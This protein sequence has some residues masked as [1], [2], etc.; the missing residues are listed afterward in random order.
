MTDV[1][2][3]VND[4]LEVGAYLDVYSFTDWR[5]EFWSDF[6]VNDRLDIGAWI[7]FDE[8]GFDGA[9]VWAELDLGN[10]EPYAGIWIYNP[11]DWGIEIG[12][13]LDDQIGTGP[14]SLIGNAQLQVG[15]CGPSFRTSS[16][17]KYEIGG[18]DDHH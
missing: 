14:Y 12:V 11:S 10:I 7:E 3:D 16:G 9:G 15:C 5:V 18:D 17:I 2:F 8:D 1:E 4:Q 6:E 13:D